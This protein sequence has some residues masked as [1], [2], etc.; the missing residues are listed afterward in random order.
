MLIPRHIKE[1]IKEEYIDTAK[2]D[3]ND[4]LMQYFKKHD[5]DNNMKLDGLELLK[6]ISNMEGKIGEK[7]LFCLIV[8]FVTL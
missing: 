3:D 8:N 2:M 4:L 5:T 7:I 6:A 1:H